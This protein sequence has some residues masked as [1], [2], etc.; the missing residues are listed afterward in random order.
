MSA[1]HLEDIKPHIIIDCLAAA[2]IRC[3]HKPSKRARSDSEAFWSSYGELWP[4]YGQHAARISRAGSYMPDSVSQGIRFGSGRSCK[5]GPDQIVQNRLRFD[6]D[7]LVRFWPN[8]YMREAIR[9]AI[10]NHPALF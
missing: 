2:R 6:L 1:R 5:E 9:C 8:A 10:E 4:S 7:D 3:E